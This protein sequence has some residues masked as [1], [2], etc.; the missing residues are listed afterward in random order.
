MKKSRLHIIPD[1]YPTIYVTKDWQSIR[2]TPLFHRES[3]LKYPT[4]QRVL[5]L[6]KCVINGSSWTSY[7]CGNKLDVVWHPSPSPSAPS[8]VPPSAPLQ[9][10]GKHAKKWQGVKGSGRTDLRVVLNDLKVEW[11]PRVWS[12][13]LWCNLGLRCARPTIHEW[14]THTVG[15]CDKWHENDAAVPLEDRLDHRQVAPFVH[16][17]LTL[18]WTNTC[19]HHDNI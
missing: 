5:H 17:K 9:I 1:G 7:M 6:Q 13:V 19:W 4:Y 16:C 10:K 15:K 2:F 18:T 8:S 3:C 12:V 11:W 14:D